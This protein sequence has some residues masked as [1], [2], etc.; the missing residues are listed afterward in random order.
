MSDVPCTDSGRIVHLFA[1]EWL[2]PFVID[3]EKSGG[4]AV[5]KWGGNKFSKLLNP[6][7]HSK[8]ML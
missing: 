4:K 7:R 3:I 1:R 6:K 5:T 2:T 8:F